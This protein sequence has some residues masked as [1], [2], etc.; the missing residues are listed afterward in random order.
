MEPPAPRVGPGR[1]L[2]V[3]WMRHRR[4]GGAAAA[5]TPAGSWALSRPRFLPL[6]WVAVRCTVHAARWC[7]SPHGMDGRK[8]AGGWI[9]AGSDS[10]SSNQIHSGRRAGTRMHGHPSSP[11]AGRVDAHVTISSKRASA[12]PP[13]VSRMLSCRRHAHAR[14][15]SGSWRRRPRHALVGRWPGLCGSS[16]MDHGLAGLRS[17]RRL[18]GCA[19]RRQRRLGRGMDSARRMPCDLTW[20]VPNFKVCVQNYSRPSSL[21]D[22]FRQESF[23]YM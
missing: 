2:L 10:Y 14:Y 21:C 12:S 3:L 22:N 16:V 11:A 4:T 5:L 15:G 17:G 9:R 23:T 1:V 6:C 7:R 18:A 13:G 20:F 19:E 8:K